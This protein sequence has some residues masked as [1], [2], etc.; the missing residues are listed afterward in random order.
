MYGQRQRQQREGLY[1][2]VSECS[3]SPNHQNAFSIYDSHFD[4]QTEVNVMENIL[5]S[6]NTAFNAIFFR[7]SISKCLVIAIGRSTE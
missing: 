5:P 6:E 2:N 3:E 1:S 7:L 4:G